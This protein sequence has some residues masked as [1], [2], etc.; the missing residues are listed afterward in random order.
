MT[1]PEVIHSI[2]HLNHLHKEH[3][4]P[5][6]WLYLFTCVTFVFLYQRLPYLPN[7]QPSNKICQHTTQW[8]CHSCLPSH[9][10]VVCIYNFTMCLWNNPCHSRVIRWPLARIHSCLAQTDGRMQSSHAHFG[11]RYKHPL[12]SKTTA[13]LACTWS[14]SKYPK[15]WSLQDK[16]RSSDIERPT[17]D[18]FSK[19]L[20]FAWAFR[21][22]T[23]VDHCMDLNVHVAILAKHGVPL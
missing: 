8:H 21:K 6:A 7:L 17:Q 15:I 20:R 2:N 12:T 10:C 16:W 13:C 11:K 4:I 9:T 5:L 19:H 1:I 18:S 14:A 22:A 23:K 3:M